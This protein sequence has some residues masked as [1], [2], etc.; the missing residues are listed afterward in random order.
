[1]GRV[2]TGHVSR[3]L[4]TDAAH[5]A[6]DP[7]QGSHAF[8]LTHRRV[9]VASITTSNSSEVKESYVC[10]SNNNKRSRLL[11]QKTAS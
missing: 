7:N 8:T 2:R 11:K 9:P 6:N 5:D 10:Y 4:S 1:M 3:A